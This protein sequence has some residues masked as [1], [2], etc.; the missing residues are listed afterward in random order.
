MT[1]NRADTARLGSA[2]PP[3]NRRS[4]K[5]PLWG[6]RGRAWI[7]NV[8]NARLARTRVAAQLARSIGTVLRPK[9]RSSD[10]PVRRSPSEQ[11][12][13][14]VAVAAHRVDMA[15]HAP[16][17]HALVMVAGEGVVQRNMRDARLLPEADFLAP[18]LFGSC[19][20]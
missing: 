9:G 1:V 16:A 8:P 6:L 2:S 18:I 14:G 3:R 4:T 7:A 19:A 20:G 15:G 12:G 11:I 10:A 13:D 5:R 17:G